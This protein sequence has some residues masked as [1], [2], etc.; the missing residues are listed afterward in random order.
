MTSSIISQKNIKEKIRQK[1][2]LE[3]L[4]QLY[5]NKFKK[6]G[7][8]SAFKFFKIPFN[9]AKKWK[10]MLIKSFSQ[11]KE[12]YNTIN[13]ANNMNYKNMKKFIISAHGGTATNHSNIKLLPNEI[14]IMSCNILETVNGS[15][16]KALING[17]ISPLNNDLIHIDNIES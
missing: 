16:I 13:P 2:K 5:K 11:Y 9:I 3:F 10:P 6:F 17:F 4:L 14:V 12:Y 8:L 1:N 7:N 15:R